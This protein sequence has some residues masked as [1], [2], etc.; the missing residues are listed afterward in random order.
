MRT[1][2]NV[3]MN[4]SNASQKL[5]PYFWLVWGLPAVVVVAALVT[6]YIAVNGA[7]EM[8]VDDYYRAG[9]AW[10]RTQV[11]DQEA[12]RRQLRARA[13]YQDGRLQ[14]ELPGV[15]SP[16]LKL[17]LSHPSE[18]ALDQ[19]LTLQADGEGRWSATATVAEHVWYVQLQ[20]EQGSWRLRAR[21]TPSQP[22]LLQA[23]VL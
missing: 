7:D 19:T 2:L 12:A 5:S 9:L 3:E 21:W 18:S 22:V 20:D 23:E 4:V 6:V 8:V 11:A 15:D 10:N 14:V 1:D 17:L 16:T 13:A